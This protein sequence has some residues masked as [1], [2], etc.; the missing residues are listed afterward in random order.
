MTALAKALKELY[1]EFDKRNQGKIE[2]YN[3]QYPILNTQ[4]SILSIG[5]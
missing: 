5:Y 2:K 4:N 1:R 3:N